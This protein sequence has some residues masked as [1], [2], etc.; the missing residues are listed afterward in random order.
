M[1]IMECP[2]MEL[3]YCSV[4]VTYLEEPEGMDSCSQPSSPAKSLVD[5]PCEQ[6]RNEGGHQSVVAIVDASRDI[7]LIALRGALEISEL[8]PGD[9]FTILWL[10][11]IRTSPSKKKLGSHGRSSGKDIM[12]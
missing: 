12:H 8:K 11:Q 6:Q 1:V 3:A 10:I 4:E 7:D 9:M 5:S 2:S